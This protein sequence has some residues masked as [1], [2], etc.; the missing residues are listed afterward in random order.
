ME[1]P[2]ICSIRSYCDDVMAS[3]FAEKRTAAERQ[4]SII[5]KS[6]QLGNFVLSLDDQYHQ[7]EVLKGATLIATIPSLVTVSTGQP[8]DHHIAT[9]VHNEFVSIAEHIKQNKI[10]GEQDKRTCGQL[11]ETAVMGL[12]CWGIANGYDSP[13]S[14]ARTATTKEDRGTCGGLRNGIDIVY[15][16]KLQGK[17]QLVQV[18]SSHNHFSNGYD[19]KIKIV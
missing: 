5:E 6:W 14:W 16:D 12:L 1:S 15:Y 9:N 17:R 8:H 10:S 11:S 4:Q 2:E 19:P 7:A 3:V 18:K 13:Q